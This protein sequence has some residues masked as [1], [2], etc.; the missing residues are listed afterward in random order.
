MITARLQATVLFIIAKDLK[1]ME[2]HIDVDEADVGM[3]KEGQEATFTVD[4]FSKLTYNTKIKQIRYSAK[5]VEN[6]VSYATI[7]DVDNSNLKLRPGMTANVDIKVAQAQNAL[8]VPNKAL[9][10]NRDFLEKVANKIGFKLEKI[11]GEKTKDEFDSIWFVENEDTF[12]EMEIELGAKEEG[13][14]QIIDKNINSNTEIVTEVEELKRE[15]MFLKQIFAKPGTI[16]R[17]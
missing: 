6:V 5:N 8:V 9:R 2:A 14:T 4:A 16:G 1:L 3:V 17:K 13:F 7:L 12:K 10:I 15:N 11:T